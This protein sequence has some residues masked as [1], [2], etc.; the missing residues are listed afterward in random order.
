M[1]NL[2]YLVP[3]LEIYSDLSEEFSSKHYFR[4]E[5]DI[6]KSRFITSLG[7]ANTKESAKF[8]IEKIKQEFADANHNCFAFILGPPKDTAN[9]GQ[10]DDGEPHGTAGK[11]MLNQLLHS[12]VGECVAVVTRY[13]GGIKL[14]PGGLVRAYQGSVAKALDELITV[15]KIKYQEL[16]LCCDY[17]SI[18]KIH[19][20]MPKFE[21]SIIN[22]IFDTQIEYTFFLPAK[23]AEN[24][25]KTLEDVSNGKIKLC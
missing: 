9:I 12:E 10:S 18:N 17:E 2:E 20:I 23:H 22:S 25:I 13:F 8:F 15:P 24:F 14:G 3:N 4:C 16:K 1:E 6:K 5:E 11:P 21:A 7:R 19:H